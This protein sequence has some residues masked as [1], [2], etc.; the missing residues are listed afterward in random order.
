VEERRSS[1][2]ELLWDLVFAFAVTQVTTLLREHLSWG[3][4]GK[5]MLVL[6]AAHAATRLV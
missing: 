4:F 2:V 6:A 1:P 3:G 5:S